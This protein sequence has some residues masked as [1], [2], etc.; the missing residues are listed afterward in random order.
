[1][2]RPTA[3]ATIGPARV[4]AQRGYLIAFG[5]GGDAVKEIKRANREDGLDIVRITA[6]ELLEH[7]RVAV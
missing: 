4:L 1:M 5:F 2:W 3:G 7:E 6:K